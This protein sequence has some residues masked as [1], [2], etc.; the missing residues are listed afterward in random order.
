MGLAQRRRT[1]ALRVRYGATKP[2]PKPPGKYHVQ[3]T[4]EE[5]ATAFEAAR[6]RSAES[7]PWEQ[8]AAAAAMRTV[9][10]RK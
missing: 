10:K 8:R 9:F 5:Q 1:R 6:R 7:R 4:D 3:P 2:M